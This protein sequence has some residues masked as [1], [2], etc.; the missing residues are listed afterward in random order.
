MGLKNRCQ[1]FIE[2]GRTAARYTAL[3]CLR[4]VG[5]V[6]HHEA[7]DVHGTVVSQNDSIEAPLEEQGVGWEIAGE[8]KAPYTQVVLISGRR[9]GDVLM[10]FLD[11]E[12]FW[13]QFSR[14]K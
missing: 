8:R 6:D 11:F 10:E 14:S 7:V 12:I 1:F 9:S 5:E 13:H 4:M 2:V 3:N